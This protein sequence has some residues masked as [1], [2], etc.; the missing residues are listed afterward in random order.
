MA[1]FEITRAD[2]G[3]AWIKAQGKTY[4]PSQVGAFVLQK[5]KETAGQ[6]SP[7][8]ISRNFHFSVHVQNIN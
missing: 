3:D 8:S 7:L 1:A 5:M 4:S 6:F 2:N